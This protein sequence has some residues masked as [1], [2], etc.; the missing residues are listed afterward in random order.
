MISDHSNNRMRG[1]FE[2]GRDTRSLLTRRSV[3]GGLGS[4]LCLGACKPSKPDE[5]SGVHSSKQASTKLLLGDQARLV[6][7]KAE[8]TNILSDAPFAFEWVNFQGAAPLFEALRAGAVDIAPA[9]DSP[10]LFAAAANVPMKV[11]AV[12][13]GP[14]SG[15]DIGLIVPADSPVRS[16]GDLK[17]RQVV[18][19]S[20]RGSISQHHLF[21]A[22]SEAGLTTRD[23][24]ISFMLP[25]DALAA[26]QA[27]HI[28]IWATFGPYLAMA[29]RAG[30]RVIR[31]AT[32]IHSGL[33][34]ITASNKALA[35]PEKTRAIAALLDRLRQAE[36]WVNTHPDLYARV[37]A[38]VTGL[39]PD[40]ASV[41]VWREQRQ[42]QPIDEAS[43]VTLQQVA[44]VFTKEH[45]FENSID[46]RPYFAANVWRGDASNG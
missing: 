6:R 31:D 16:V 33:A 28:G 3:M 11:V 14:N 9:G 18:V 13:V 30:G 7:A 10:V 21:G 23:V 35:D 20:A 37:F 2:S 39:P 19:S 8:A 32:G 38:Q 17:G 36:I 41:I 46:V 43:I 34:F 1:I 5:E 22:L 4:M 29:E 24:Q 15:Q 42:L 25:V 26:F 40:V 45:V 12:S 44:N 27:G